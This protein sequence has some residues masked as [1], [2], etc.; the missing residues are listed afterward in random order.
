MNVKCVNS[1]SV[2]SWM[3]CAMSESS[4]ARA[5]VYALF[6]LPPGTSLS[7][8]PPSSL[9]CCQKSVSRISAAERNRRIASSPSVRRW[10]AEA[11]GTLANN[12]APSAPAPAP[13]KKERRLLRCRRL[14]AVSLIGCASCPSWR[15]SVSDDRLDEE[16]SLLILCSLLV[17]GKRL[18][19]IALGGA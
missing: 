12:P 19:K 16:V 17:V 2:L 18:L 4:T 3:Y 14:A 8:T 9:Y 10:C 7:W 15:D 13:T 5:A 11:S 1:S 6:P